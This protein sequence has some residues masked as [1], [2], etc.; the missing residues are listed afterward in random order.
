MS[1][2][3]WRTRRHVTTGSLLT[4]GVCLATYDWRSMYDA[5]GVDLKVDIFDNAMDEVVNLYCPEVTSCVRLNDKF[6]VS[7]RLAEL[8]E[9]KSKEYK[10]HK[11]S[12]RY[13]KLR[14]EIK[15]E[16][17]AS[18]SKKIPKLSGNKPN[19]IRITT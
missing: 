16:I 11:N 2:Y 8:S 3:E 17:L 4:L 19:S 1:R 9:E 15:E 14:R 10:A 18:N 13:K 12:N 7:A 5:K 6:Y